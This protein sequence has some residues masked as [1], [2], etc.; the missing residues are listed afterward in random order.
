MG[1]TILGFGC[2]G[3]KET[4]STEQEATEQEDS[5]S[6][7]EVEEDSENDNNSSTDDS[8]KPDDS[9]D[10]PDSGGYSE[11]PEGFDPTASCEGSWEETLCTYDGLVWWCQDGVWLNEED[12]E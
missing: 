3:D 2:R 9:G 4:E 6:W 1:L 11:C 5:G 12:K 8:G 10:K 7:W